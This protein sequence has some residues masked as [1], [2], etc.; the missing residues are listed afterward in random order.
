[1]NNV[2]AII[3]AGGTGTRMGSGIPKQYIKVSNKEIIKWTVEVF[4][5]CDAFDII[6]IAVPENWISHT[7]ELFSG[8]SNICV[9]AGGENR[10]ETICKSIS[11]IDSNYHTDDRTVVLTHDAARPCVSEKTVLECIDSISEKTPCSTV[12]IPA[13]DSFAMSSDGKYI[14]SYQDRSVLYHIQ[15]PQTFLLK[16]YLSLAAKFPEAS[17]FTEAT[18]LFRAA[19]HDVAMIMGDKRNIKVTTVE[20]LEMIRMFLQDMS[21]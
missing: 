20:D 14:S 16:E 7:E 9:I 18:Q 1:M 10:N 2:Y 15:T 13:T 17:S 11:Y 19:G 21:V 4:L 5:R 12:T 8:N 6:I 3:A